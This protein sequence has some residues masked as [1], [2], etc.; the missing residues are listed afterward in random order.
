[1]GPARFAFPSSCFSWC[2]R[3]QWASV[4]ADEKRAQAE[5]DVAR[6][7]AF[8]RLEK[9]PQYTALREERQSAR[10]TLA[11]ADA[12]DSHVSDAEVAKTTDLVFADG[13]KMKQMENRVLEDDAKYAQAKTRLDAAR[14]RLDQLDTE[15][16]TELQSQP[17]CQQVQQQLDQA[18]QQLAQARQQLAQA[19]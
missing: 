17:E 14:S 13:L 15:V 4:V 10:Q 8:A 19:A 16:T 7:A 9:D 1:V 11:T 12:A 5:F 6:K 2:W 18:T 3:Y